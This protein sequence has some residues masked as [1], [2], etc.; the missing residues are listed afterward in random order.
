MTYD[1]LDTIVIPFDD[2]KEGYELN[3]SYHKG[4]ASGFAKLFLNH[5]T[6]QQQASIKYL[7]GPQESRTYPGHWLQL[8]T[9][10]GDADWPYPRREQ[11]EEEY[12]RERPDVDLQS[13]EIKQSISEEVETYKQEWWGRNR[14]EEAE[15]GDSTVAI[16]WI[17]GDENN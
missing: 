15:I 13:E 8:K 16:E 9:F 2:F 6:G 5:I 12:R 3:L 10:V 1:D 14:L 17:F 7:D 4:R 11:I